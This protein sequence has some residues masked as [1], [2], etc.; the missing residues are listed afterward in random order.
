[1]PESA[2]GAAVR[3][4]ASRFPTSGTK[5]WVRVGTGRGEKGRLKISGCFRPVG[6]ER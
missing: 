6:G 5:C 2:T 3:D 1:M 4:E